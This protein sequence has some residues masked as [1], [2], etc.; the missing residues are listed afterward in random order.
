MDG[1][2]TK[3]EQEKSISEENIQVENRSPEDEA[4]PSEGIENQ[5]IEVNMPT[6]SSKKEEG[7][8]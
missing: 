8:R 7:R 4:K 5:S 6:T 1:K 3:K 2:V